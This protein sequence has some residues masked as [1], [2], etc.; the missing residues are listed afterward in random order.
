MQRSILSKDTNDK[1]PKKIWQ[2]NENFL[3]QRKN[4]KKRERDFGFLP[5]SITL[6]E[7]DPQLVHFQFV[8]SLFLFFILP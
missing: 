8:F 7:S 2:A 5:L 3:S 6:S 1:Q 4:G